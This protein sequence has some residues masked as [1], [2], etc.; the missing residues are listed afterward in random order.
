M[1]TPNAH[2]LLRTHSAG[3]IR[4]LSGQR[5]VTAILCF[6][7]YAMG[8]PDASS[9][10]DLYV[11]C[12]PQ[13]AAADER[14]VALVQAGAVTELH[15]ERDQ[16]GWKDQWCPCNDRLRLNGVQ[17][18]LIYNT[19]GWVQAVVRQV[20]TSGATSI[21]ELKF[22][23]YTFLG[24]L[25]NSVILYDAQGILREI[26][27]GLYPYPPALR[28]ALMASSLE[29]MHGSLEDMQ[30]YTRRSIGNSAFLFHLWRVID[31]LETLLFALNR[32]YSPA[33]KRLEEAYRSLPVLPANFLERYDDLLLTPLTPP[34]RE[35]IVAGLQALVAEIEELDRPAH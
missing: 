21:P 3:L 24:L 35:K 33:T 28:Q 26:V 13:I 25:E 22:R 27:A 12:H 6:G 29:A 32:R 8:T 7:S 31:G 16:A 1:N 5:W 11:V 4:A 34:G 9:D 30:D 10:I 18:D 23:P 2:E 20:K 19:Q 15:L 17:Y 14:Q